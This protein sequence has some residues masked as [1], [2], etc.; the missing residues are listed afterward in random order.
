MGYL[1]VGVGGQNKAVYK[2]HL[3]ILKAPRAPE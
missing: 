1:L 2:L 3:T